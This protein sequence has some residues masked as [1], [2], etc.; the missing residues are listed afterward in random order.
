MSGHKSEKKGPNIICRV[1]NVTPEMVCRYVERLPKQK[2]TKDAFRN[3]MGKKWFQNEHQAPEQWGLYYI[4]GTNYYPRFNHNIT[5]KE[6]DAYLYHWMRNLI[7]V[8]PY[9]RFKKQS[10]KRLVES[11]VDQLEKNPNEH[12]LKTIIRRIIDSDEPFVINEIIANALNNYSMALKVEIIN[13]DEERYNV[14]LLPNYKELLKSKNNMTKKE[15]FEL[16]D[17]VK[18]AFDPNAPLQKIFYG[19]PG[20]GKSKT[21][22]RIVDENKLPCIRTTF[23]PDSDYSTFVGAYK[24]SIGTGRVYGAQGPLTEGGKPIEEPKITY[25]FVKQAFMKAYLGAWKKYADREGDEAVPQFLVVEEINRGNCAQIF[26]DLFQLL[27]RG[28]NKF[29]EYPIEAD[30]DLQKEIERAFIEEK[31]GNDKNPYKLVKDIEIEGV[32]EGYIS[33][34]G[35]TLSEDVQHGRVLLLPKNLY[36]WAT[37]NTSDQSLFPIDSAFKRRWD[38][39]YMPIE[40]KNENWTIKIGEKD[41]NWVDFQRK[42]NDKIYSV[43]NSEDK[44]LGDYFVNADRTGNIIS[45]NTLLNK[46]LFY[47]W[48]DVC[49]DDP[50]QIFQWRDD[51]DNNKEKSIKFSEFFCEEKE[52]DRKLQGFMAFL[53]IDDKD[54]KVSVGQD[55]DT[56]TKENDDVVNS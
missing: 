10:D 55:N 17:D 48:N 21:I 30:T 33:N 35:A 2:M 29:S 53:K 42:I 23:H 34:Y 14:S 25:K 36:I 1:S 52:R 41:Y 6:A 26:G 31:D 37:M 45:A 20:T 49:K 40:Y 43:D 7:I 28:E 38:W 12:D 24:P 51:Q 11:I 4:D 32:V 8:N 5:I 22:K 27:D 16:F 44:Q 15:Y 47:I 3:Y 39:E 46:I 54:V 18:T 19:A 13:K 56:T 9:T 50:D